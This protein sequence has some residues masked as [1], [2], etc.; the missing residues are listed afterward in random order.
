MTNSVF[1]GIA[2][3][4]DSIESAGKSAYIISGKQLS[5]VIAV[6]DGALRAVKA[7]GKVC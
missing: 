1:S 7:I 4:V 5:A 3:S 2:W 6:K